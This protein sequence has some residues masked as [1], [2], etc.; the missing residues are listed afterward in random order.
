MLNKKALVG[1]ARFV[2]EFPFYG[3]FH[4]IVNCINGIMLGY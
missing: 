3:F 2:S 4:L 1:G